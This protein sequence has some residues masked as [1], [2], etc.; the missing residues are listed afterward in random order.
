MKV[1]SYNHSSENEIIDDIIWSSFTPLAKLANLGTLQSLEVPLLLSPELTCP[2][3]INSMFNHFFKQLRN[4]VNR[5]KQLILCDMI[6]L[7]LPL[8]VIKNDREPPEYI[9]NKAE[10]L[11]NQNED[12]SGSVLASEFIQ[13]RV[14]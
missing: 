3:N 11:V 5:R 13:Y 9:L 6:K 10:R 14:N 2:D 8:I 12:I 7:L 1:R 4:G